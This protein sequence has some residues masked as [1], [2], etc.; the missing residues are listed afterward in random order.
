MIKLFFNNKIT[1]AGLLL[2]SVLA[3]SCKKLIEIPGNPPTAITETQQFTDSATT[4]TAVVGVYSYTAFASSGFMYNNANF[5]ACTSVSA[6]DLVFTAQSDVGM[7]QFNTNGVN[8]QNSYANTLWSNPY[9]GIYIVNTILNNIAANNA[10]SASFKTQITGEMK[11]VRAFYYFNTVNLFG[12]IPLVLSTD[13][14]KTA[15]LPRT[16]VDGIYAQIL[17]DL[18][19]AQKALPAA[20]PSEGRVRPNLYTVL[21]LLSKVQLYRKQWQAAYDAANTVIG[22]G[23]Y[24]LES[25]PNNVFHD[26]S[27]EAI[28]QLP[29]TGSN[30][31]TQ[32]AS[33]FIPY[34]ASVPSYLLSPA[35][36][37]A[38][39]AGDLRRDS[40]VQ[41]YLVNV[42][43]TDQHFFGPYKYKNLN[44]TTTPYTEDYMIFR[45]ADLYLIRAEAAAHLGKTTEAMADLNIVRSRAGLPAS[46][47][48]TADDIIT[49][50]LR[51]RRIEF[52][53]EWANRWFDLKRTG[54]IDAV[55][56]VEKS[57][58]KPYLA[59][60]PV[61]RQQRQFNTFLTQNPGY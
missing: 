42:N 20:Y 36:L 14:K 22:S 35:L 54:T 23:L 26:G 1:I 28:W 47:A 61:P 50:I 13:Y 10:F 7:Q 44:A 32:E 8:D 57:G 55:L 27:N 33:T 49:A 59:L 3:P 40:W 31:V 18:A 41:D 37:N 38:F 5:T 43:G 12:D 21:S 48:T 58:W 16:S 11:M 2:I 6:N 34:S 60:Y 24:T 45:V 46:T 56:S 17:S 25:D 29:A 19:D 9:T 4:M 52:F 39:E 30:N 51:E 15:V 53:C